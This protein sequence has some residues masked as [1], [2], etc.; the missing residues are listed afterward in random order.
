M[1]SD[2][3]K[4]SQF[5]QE[6]KRRKVVHV[7]IVYA[8]TAFAILEL[9]DIVAPSLG[10]P[11]WTLNFDPTFALAFSSLALIYRNKPYLQSFVV[12]AVYAFLRNKE[13]AFENL[14]KTDQRDIESLYTV[15]YVKND[16]SFANYSN[17]P[18]F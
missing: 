3:D 11:D 7:I 15:N 13:L 1:P 18:V 16:P 10:F 4:L 8:A 5:W 17:D 2:P 9:T 12:A 6:L 14:S